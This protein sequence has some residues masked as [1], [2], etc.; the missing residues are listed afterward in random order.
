M[1]LYPNAS[2]GL[3]LRTAVQELEK[4]GTVLSESGLRTIQD[5][6]W[7]TYVQIMSLAMVIAVLVNIFVYMMKY[8]W[9]LSLM[10]TWPF[11]F[12]ILS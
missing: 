11:K 10:F 6:L 4:Q 7:L 8:K 2:S 12:M 5:Y 9:L 1:I 3:P